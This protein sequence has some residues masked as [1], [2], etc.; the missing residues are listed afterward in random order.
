MREQGRE[1]EEGREGRKEGRAKAGAIS[2][3]QTSTLA[4]NRGQGHW[5]GGNK[6]NSN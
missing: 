5:E 6:I 3:S 2:S 1:G 4:L